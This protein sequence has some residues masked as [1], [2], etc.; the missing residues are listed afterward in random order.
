LIGEEHKFGM[1]KSEEIDASNWR[2]CYDG[3]NKIVNGFML[4]IVPLLKSKG[5]GGEHCMGKEKGENRP[6]EL[7]QR[8]PM[9]MVWGIIT[10]RREHIRF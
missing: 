2:S 8:S 4:N 5:G 10:Y 1:I 3:E 9:D 7:T 6:I